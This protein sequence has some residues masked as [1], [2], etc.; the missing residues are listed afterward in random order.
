ML[1]LNKINSI[2]IKIC[3]DDYQSWKDGRVEMEEDQRFSF[4]PNKIQFYW[5][6]AFCWCLKTLEF[7]SKS[8]IWTS[9]PRNWKHI[10]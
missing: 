2:L 5:E 8:Y 6:L 10:K 9:E 7:F 4:E 3:D 1:K